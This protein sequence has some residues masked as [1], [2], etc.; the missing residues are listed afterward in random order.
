VPDLKKVTPKSRAE[1]R[2]WLEKHHA[3]APGVWLVYAKKNAGVPTLSYTDAVE[4]A[5]CFGWIDSLMKSIDER[6]HMQTFT[7]RKPKS[8]W[9]ALNKQR[10]EK[11]IAGGLMTPPGLKQIE[12][13]KANGRW[14]AHAETDALTVPPDLKKALNASAT[15][16][17]HWP[18]YTASQ[19]KAFLRMVHDAKTPET[20]A[21]RIARVL[22]IVSTKTSFSEVVKAA[23]K[24][25]KKT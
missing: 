2:A 1:W 6:F 8:A 25:G 17:T 5:L 19:Q 16:R 18:T 4:E 14:E 3:T 21:K 24:G 22:E 9:S 13:A 23:M 7:P 12:L 20:R 10:V 11:L 15:A